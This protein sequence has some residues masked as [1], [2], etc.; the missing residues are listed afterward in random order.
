MTYNFKGFKDY[1]SFSRGEKNG[2]LILIIIV[3][4]LLFSPLVLKTFVNPIPNNSSEFYIKV[5]SFFSSL[6]IQPEDFA[7]SPSSPIEQEVVNTLAKEPFFFDPNSATINE[8]ID[9]GLSLKQANV[10]LNYRNKGGVFQVSEDLSKIYVID[11]K[12]Y[13]RLKPWIRITPKEFN[14]TNFSKKDTLNKE[15]LTPIVVDLNSADT[16]QLVKIKGI[17][18]AFARRIVAYR[19]LLGGFVEI[20]QLKEVYGIK[21]E[22]VIAITSQIIVEVNSIVHINLNLVSLDDLKKHPYISEYQAKAIIYYRSKVGTIK[23]VTELVDNK[24]L[25]MDVFQKVKHYLVTS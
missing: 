9:L 19:T 16:V 20:N 17:G 22:L 13:E 6:K 25:P 4:L 14:K 8:F 24:I 10:V 7:T 2:I 3:T 18:N 5:D 11:S 15:D 23:N 21:P 12:T 1:F